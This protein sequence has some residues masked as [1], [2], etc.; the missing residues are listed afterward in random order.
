LINLEITKITPAEAITKN[1]TV[2]ADNSEEIIFDSI[3]LNEGLYTVAI[4]DLKDYIEVG[5]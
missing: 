2:G 3:N 4:G 1:V 5:C